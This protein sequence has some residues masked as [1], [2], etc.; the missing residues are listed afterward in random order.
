MICRWE[1]CGKEFEHKN[2]QVKYCSKKCKDAAIKQ[3]SKE[4]T[5]RTSKEREKKRMEKGTS[6]CKN[7]DCNKDFYPFRQNNKFCCHKCNAAFHNKQRKQRERDLDDLI[8]ECIRCHSLYKPNHKRRKLCDVCRGSALQNNTK[9]TLPKKF[10]ERGT[11]TYPGYT[12][13]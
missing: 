12:D 10:L 3:R 4:A 11:I 13:I 9:V 1:K 5:L 2:K 7:P 8:Y 6:K